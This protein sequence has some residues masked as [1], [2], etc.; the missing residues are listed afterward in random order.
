[1]NYPLEKVRGLW[2]RLHAE[3]DTLLAERSLA[4]NVSPLILKIKSYRCDLLYLIDM[5]SNAMGFYN[6][7]IYMDGEYI[8]YSSRERLSD[9]WF[10]QAKKGAGAVFLLWSFSACFNNERQGRH[11]W[12]VINTSYCEFNCFQFIE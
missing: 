7:C 9:D 2:S 10:T 5:S 12:D 11:I 1:M 8:Q 4:L 3:G 6:I